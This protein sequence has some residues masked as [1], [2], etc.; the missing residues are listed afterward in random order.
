MTDPLTIAEL[1]CLIH[2]AI[3]SYV[4]TNGLEATRPPIPLPGGIL[5][6]LP[7]LAVAILQEILRTIDDQDPNTPGTRPDPT[8][9]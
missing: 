6:P 9:N 4:T 5:I 7:D 8:L 2:G 3:T 1:S